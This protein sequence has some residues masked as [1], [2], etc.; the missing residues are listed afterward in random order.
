MMPCQLITVSSYSGQIY[1][2]AYSKILESSATLLLRVSDL[3]FR[4]VLVRLDVFNARRLS[5]SRVVTDLQSVRLDVAPRV[6]L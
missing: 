6:G 5:Q 4:I 3:T 2:V 1:T